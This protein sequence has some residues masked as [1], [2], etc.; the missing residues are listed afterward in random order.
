VVKRLVGDEFFRAIAHVYATAELPRSPVMLYYGETFPS[1]TIFERVRFPI[2]ARDG[3][4]A[5][6]PAPSNGPPVRSTPIQLDSQGAALQ[7]L[8]THT[9]ER[10]DRR[11]RRC[12]VLGAKTAT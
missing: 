11:E 2:S 7:Q 5:R 8:P 10:R 6:L 4:R 3:A 12:V 1:S 9:G